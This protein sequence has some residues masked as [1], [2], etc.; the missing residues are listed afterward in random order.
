MSSLVASCSLSILLVP[1]DSRRQELKASGSRRHRTS[2]SH[3][4]HSVTLLQ[5]ARV[6]RSTCHT[7]TRHLRTYSKMRWEETRRHSWWPALVQ[8]TT[9]ARKP[10]ARLTS[11]PEPAASKWA[12]PPKT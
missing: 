10:S 3:C 8:W 1:S 12:R 11:L 2:T 4:R 6:S 5:R 9:T 7:E